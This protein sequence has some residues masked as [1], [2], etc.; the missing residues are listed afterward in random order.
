MVDRFLRRG[1]RELGLVGLI[2]TFGAIATAASAAPD[3]GRASLT[4]PTFTQA[5]AFDVSRPLTELAKGPPSPNAHEFVN[6]RSRNAPVVD[7][8]HSGDGAA[9]SQVGTLAI[10]GPVA[11]FEGLSNQDNFNVFGFRVNPPDPVGDVG[12][13]HYVE[14]INLVFGVFDKAGNKLL[15]PVDTGT[16]WAGFPIEDCT[17]PSGDPIV[18]YDQTVDRWILT[19]FTTRGLDDPSLPFYNCVA[20]SQTGDPTGAYFRYAFITQADPD[21]GFF[22]PDYPKYGV[23][24]DT[25]VMTTRDFGSVDGYGI[26]VYGLEK[27]KMVDGNPNAR[28]VQFFLDSDV[29][30]INL[31]GDGLLPPDL[32]GKQKPRED[33]KIPVVGTQD[34][35]GPYGATFDALNIWEFDVKWRSTP[36]ASL[37]LKSQLP[38]APFDS[39]FPCAPT[40]RDC[41]PQ[42]GI[43][44]PAQFLDILSY[45]QRPTWRLAYRN[46]KDFEA[47][48]TTQSVEAM[49]GVAGMRWYELR[50]VGDAYSIFQQGTYAPADGVHRWMGSV[51]QDK[52]GGMALGYSVVNATTVFPGIRYTGRLAGDPLGQLTL[53][54]GTIIDGSGVQR[55]TNSRWGDYTSMNVDPVDDCTFWYVNEYYTAA[56]QASS[57]A[58]WQTRI[59]SFK[60]PGC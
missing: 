14:M 50:R 46:N 58:G 60:L 53:G 34:D 40:S 2:V 24:R 3:S 45:R 51:A 11:N 42:P 23:W 28:A 18:L 37:V 44:N 49:P 15:G 10:P 16:L 17:D 47:L 4:S 29:V 55:T 36:T 1:L 5:A 21:G 30:P 38:T 56:G 57:V 27:N 26:S 32:D 35:G 20:I 7:G 59:A 6:T 13:N 25:Y 8:P 19:Q 52:N 43:T 31:I 12:P 48:V 54:E 39:I 41:L 22:F 9:Q 33:A